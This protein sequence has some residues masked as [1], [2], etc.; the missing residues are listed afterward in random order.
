MQESDVSKSIELTI[1]TE[2]LAEQSNPDKNRFVF[3]YTIAIQ[4]KSEHTVKL[5]SRYWLI[6]DGNGKKVE[7]QGDGVVGEQPSIS[8]DEQ[9]VYSSGAVLDTPVGTMEGYYNMITEHDDSPFKALI[10]VFRLAQP[11]ILN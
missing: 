7:V 8:A 2:F 3:A 1:Q 6:T 5:N 9:Y 10:P 11:N 4:N